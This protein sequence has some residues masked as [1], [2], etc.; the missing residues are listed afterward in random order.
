[1]ADIKQ[2]FVPN[3]NEYAQQAQVY[4]NRPAFKGT[5]VTGEMLAEAARNTHAQYGRTV[6]LE[7]ALA[8]GQLETRF[9]TDS[10]GRKNYRNNIYNV[11]E[12][13]NKTV[14]RPKNAR[15]GIARYFDLLAKDYLSARTPDVLLEGFYN[16]NGDRYASK[17]TYEK[18]L[19]EQIDYIK[20][21]I[22]THRSN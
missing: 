19:R 22:A 5:P 15:E 6:P 13:D 14:Y 20:N 16:V 11:G 8:Q 10:S 9:G 17:P 21:Y 3:W 1:M 4:L 18:E 7:L 12:Y 2:E